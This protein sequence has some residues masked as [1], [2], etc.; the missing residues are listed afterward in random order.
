MS[1]WCRFAQRHIPPSGAMSVL[2]SW[3]REYSTE[4]AFD[5]VTRLA[6]NPVDSRLRRVLLSIRCDTLPSWRHNFPC[7][8]GLS[9]SENRI[10]GVHLPIKIEGG[11]FN[12]CTVFIVSC[13]RRKLLSEITSSNLPSHLSFALGI[14]PSCQCLRARRN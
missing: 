12:S 4:M 14:V 2:P 6:I 10:L 11:I 5:P 3:V 7:R 8:Q 1:L 9:L 13:L